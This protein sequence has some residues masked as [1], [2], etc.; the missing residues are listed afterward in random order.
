VVKHCVIISHLPPFVCPVLGNGIY[1][2]LTF[3][4]LLENVAKVS[5]HPFM[6]SALTDLFLLFKKF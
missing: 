3:D 2:G 5:V 1:K 4:M 6:L